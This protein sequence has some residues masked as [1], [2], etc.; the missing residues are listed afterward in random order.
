MIVHVCQRATESGAEQIIVATDDERIFN[1]V[2][3][4][5]FQA[6]MTRSDH[7]SGTDRIAE[8]SGNENWPD[9]T[10]IV[11]IQGDE[12]LVSVSDIQTLINT[13][14]SQSKADVA[15]I[16]TPITTKEELFDPNIVKVVTDLNQYALYF[17]RAT[18]PWDRDG[19]SDNNEKLANQHQRHLGLYAYRAGFLKRFVSMQDSPIET[20]EKLEQ[21]RILWNGESIIVA[22]VSSKPTIGV[23]TP[24]DLLR[25][26]QIMMNNQ[27]YGN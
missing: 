19:F 26:E 27:Q 11:N 21:L 8:V 25:V 12:P 6:V 14:E 5:G 2:E 24:N 18:I 17:S 7:A 1:T 15:T 20:L 23:D 10:L 22:S 9:E 13:L 16:S 4:A 3:H